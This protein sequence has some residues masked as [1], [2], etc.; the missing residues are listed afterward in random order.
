MAE[1]HFSLWQTADDSAVSGW[2][3]F[4]LASSDRPPA[5]PHRGSMTV[6][7]ELFS[8]QVWIS[9]QYSGQLNLNLLYSL[10]FNAIRAQNDL[11]GSTSHP[12]PPSHT[13]T[14]ECSSLYVLVPS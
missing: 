13:H 11:S 1:R 12:P 6:G 2:E 10:L 3:V 4:S 7:H 14:Q 5:E 8:G 9:H